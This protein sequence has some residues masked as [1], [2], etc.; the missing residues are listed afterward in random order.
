MLLGDLGRQY[1][2][3]ERRKALSQY[4]ESELFSNK[5]RFSLVKNNANPNNLAASPH[6]Q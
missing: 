6:V 4:D 3:T 1:L 2:T 5:V